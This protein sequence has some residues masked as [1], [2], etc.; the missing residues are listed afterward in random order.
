MKIKRADGPTGRH[1]PGVAEIRVRFPVGP[2]DT[3]GNRIGLGD[4]LLTSCPG[5]GVGGFDS[6]TFRLWLDGEMEIMPGF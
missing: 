5:N 3:E 2:L 6:P 4:W 1:R